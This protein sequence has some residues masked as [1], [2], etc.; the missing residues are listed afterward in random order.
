VKN[1][2]IRIDKMDGVEELGDLMRLLHLSLL[3]MALYLIFYV[4]SHFMK[5][6]E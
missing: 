5:E 3:A 1:G 2:R 4:Y 6:N